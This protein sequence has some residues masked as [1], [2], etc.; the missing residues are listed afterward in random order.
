MLD[1]LGGLLLVRCYQVIDDGGWVWKV[2]VGLRK[3]WISKYFRVIDDD[4]GRI[5]LEKQ[6]GERPSYINMSIAV[7]WWLME[8]LS[9]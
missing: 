1:M 2:D 3:S 8:R 5:R 6:D 4:G 9:D 7:E